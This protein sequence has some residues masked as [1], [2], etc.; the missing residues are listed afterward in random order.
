MKL[1]DFSFN[2]YSDCCTIVRYK[3]TDTDLVI[4]SEIEHDGKKYTITE[5]GEAA[6]RI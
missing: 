3:G 4:P 6:F 1:E 2:F 5:I